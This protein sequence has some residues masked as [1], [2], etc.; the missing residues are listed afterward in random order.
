MPA[1]WSRFTSNCTQPVDFGDGN[2]V[3]IRRVGWKVL[4][5]AA[6]ETQARAIEMMRSV[7]SEAFTK[8]FVDTIAALGGGSSARKAVE[9]DPFER[10][11]KATLLLHGIVSWP[12]GSPPTVAGIEDLDLTTADTLA[13]AIY[14]LSCPPTK[15]DR[16]ND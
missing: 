1:P 12:D 10:Y 13:R 4:E 5:R 8:Q 9:A 11:D 16:K 3:T 6:A 15:D 7:G 2:V 14:A